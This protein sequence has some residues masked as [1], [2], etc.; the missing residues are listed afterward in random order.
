MENLEA[1]VVLKKEI[2]TWEIKILE[3]RSYYRNRSYSLYLSIAI[4]SAVTTILL[5][6]KID[7][8]MEASRIIALIFSAGVTVLTAV[9]VFFN[10]K[11]LWIAND[12]AIFKLGRISFDISMAEA[13]N[14]IDAD[15]IKEFRNRLEGILQDLNNT[16]QKSRQTRALK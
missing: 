2:Q 16:W 12:T 9:S 7:R 1:L 6:L 8:L 13:N 4:A 11:D 15:L 3:R 5:G 14:S 10:Y